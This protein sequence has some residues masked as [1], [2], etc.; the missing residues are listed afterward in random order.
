MEVEHADGQPRGKISWKLLEAWWA[1]ARGP[2]VC[3]HEARLQGPE[4]GPGWAIFPQGL[5]G[6]HLLP[7]FL[8]LDSPQVG[9]PPSITP[10]LSPSPTEA[11]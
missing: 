3:A 7:R 11:E 9:C 6:W 4:P 10:N 5:E 2:G 1:S 8:I